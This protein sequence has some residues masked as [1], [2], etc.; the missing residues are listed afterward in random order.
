MSCGYPSRSLRPRAACLGSFIP[1]TDGNDLAILLKKDTFEP[2]AAVFSISE[3]SSSKDI[4]GTACCD[5]LPFQA[6]PR[7]R[8]AQSMFTTMLPRNA[9]L[10]LLSCSAFTP[11]WCSTT[12]VSSVVTST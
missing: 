4:W 3:A 2:D 6:S 9:T 11:I 8:S 10:P 7:S 12:L 5:A 1:Y